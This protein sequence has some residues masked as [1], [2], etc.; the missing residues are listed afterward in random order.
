MARKR[1]GREGREAVEGDLVRAMAELTTRMDRL[2][3]Q[4]FGA[5]AAVTVGDDDTDG[6]ANAIF[7]VPLENAVRVLAAL[8]SAPR[9]ALYRAALDGPVASAALMA[10]AGL[11]TTGQLY[12][13]LR[14][15]VGVGLMA[16]EGR[17][18]YAAVQERIPAV[19]AILR[20]ALDL[21]Q[22]A[23][24]APSLSPSSVSVSVKAKHIPLS[25]VPEAATRSSA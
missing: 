10:A 16:Q 9:L 18:R 19:R 4:M 5:A 23:P 6:K 25:S 17:D 14:E 8:S 22:I 11:N 1:E 24:P 2:E 15:L 13:H 7:A 20:A 12:H 3:G 21:A